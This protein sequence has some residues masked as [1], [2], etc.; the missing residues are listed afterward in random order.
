MQKLILTFIT[1]LICTVI[2]AQQKPSEIYTDKNGVMRYSDTRKEASF[3]GINYT[4]PFAHAYRAI[5]YLEKNHKEAIDKDVYHFARLG[6]NAYRIHIWDVE[7]SDAKG[8]LLTNDHLDLLD[9][10]IYKLKER[11]IKTVLTTMTTFG[12]GYPERNQTTDGFSYLYDKCEVHNHPEAQKAQQNYIA[13]LATHVNPYTGKAYMNDPDVVGFEINNEPC[14]TGTQED[15]KAYIDGM[16]AALKK[17]GNRKPVF[18][19]VA[20]SS[21]Y[22]EAYY[23]TAVQG[24]TYQWYPI[25]LVAGKS[26]TGNFLP[27]VDK[28]NIPFGMHKG[29]ASKARLIYEYDPAD[30]LYSYIHPAMV[31]TLRT[32]G[33]QWITQFAYDPIDMARYNTE[34]QTHFLNLAYTP[35]KAISMKIAAEVAYQTPRNKSYGSYPADTLFA[36]FRVSYSQDL[37]ELNS[38]SKF[39]YSNNT[40]AN[41][42]AVDKLESIAGTGTSPVVSYEGTG[43]Y[44]L[45]KLEEGVWR[46][47]V[48]PDAVVVNDPFAKASLEKEVTQIIWNQWNMQINLPNLG[49]EFSVSALNSGNNFGCTVANGTIHNLHP[50]TYLLREK[51]H[52]PT[53]QWNKDTRWGTIALGEFVA[54][55]AHAN[56]YSVVHSAG[57]VIERG[58]PYTIEACVAGPEMPDSVIVYTDNISFWRKNNPYYKL[59]RVNGYTY[60]GTIPAEEI[61]NDVFGYNIL[62]CK[63]NNLVTFPSGVNK[64]PLDWDYIDTQYWKCMVVDS[65]SPIRLFT[66]HQ[67]LSDGMETYTIPEWSEP[68]SQEPVKQIR[69]KDITREIAFRKERLLACKEVCIH[70]KEAPQT[71]HIGFITNMG[72]TYSASFA[73][74]KGINRIPLSKLK[75]APTAILPHSYPVFLDKY[76]EPAI[77]IPFQLK[78][79]EKVEIWV[80]SEAGK[81]TNLRIGNIWLQ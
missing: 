69:K 28:Y 54:P 24:T 32:A 13:Q 43:A 81:S 16:L 63:N 33:F 39:Y 19:N 42:V 58:K 25:G 44:F 14:H 77:D 29:Y 56:T 62:I 8:N 10:L 35:K 4:L 2:Q 6:F 41:P 66:S 45:D 71:V 34:Y 76:F 1:C 65:Q 11:N 23:S 47:E 68:Q 9:Y 67:E 20:Q 50:G 15:V 55:Q 3:F 59:E 61:Q 52:T 27:Y 70:L 17:A 36:D 72:Y 78:D 31:R 64:S 46:L 37:S 74:Q 26:R 75:S 7:I 18:Y 60:R 49:H 48:M 12:N 22:A 80:E 30:V 73:A 38:P 79:I 5:G 53:R 57:K 21:Y 40:A 51:N